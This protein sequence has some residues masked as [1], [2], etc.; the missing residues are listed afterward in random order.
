MQLTLLGGSG[1]V[2]AEYCSGLE[3]S[4]LKNLLLGSLTHRSVCPYNLTSG[5]PRA[6]E[7]KGCVQVSKRAPKEKSF[8]LL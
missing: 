8:S 1:S 2:S 7:M 5:F 4:L 6:N 3:T